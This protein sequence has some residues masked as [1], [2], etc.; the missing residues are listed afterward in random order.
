MSPDPSA[1]QRYDHP[2]L[3]R[4]A[5]VAVMRERDRYREAL[6]TICKPEFELR[7]DRVEIAR[8]ALD[9]G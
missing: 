4:F 7:R 3:R 2:D 5:V 9:R 1:A 8:E 6:E